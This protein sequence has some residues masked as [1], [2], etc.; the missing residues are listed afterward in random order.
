MKWMKIPG[1]ALASLLLSSCESPLKSWD[2]EG[3]STTLPLIYV[4]FRSESIGMTSEGH[5]YW[6]V[7]VS[8]DSK[9]LTRLEICVR[10]C[11]DT[12]IAGVGQTVSVVDTCTRV[13]RPT[14]EGIGTTEEFVFYR[15]SSIIPSYQLSPCI[16]S[17][18]AYG[19]PVMLSTPLTT[20]VC[21][22]KGN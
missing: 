20:T 19:C 9:L 13:F 2:E 6:R 3:S 12:I 16:E 21:L 1:I 15:I 10:V 17:S 22:G 18:S 5:P 8:S 4:H 7:S 14:T 11:K